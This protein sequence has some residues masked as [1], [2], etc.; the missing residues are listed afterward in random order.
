MDVMNE[1]IKIIHSKA[2][3]REVRDCSF[4]FFLPTEGLSISGHT[5]V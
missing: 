3:E 4:V 1:C 5:G 2:S